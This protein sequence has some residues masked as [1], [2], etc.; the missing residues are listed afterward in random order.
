M[1]ST[2]ANISVP[3]GCNVDRQIH[4][5]P[6]LPRTEKS[7][8]GGVVVSKAPETTRRQTGAPAV[9]DF[10]GRTPRDCS[11]Q[12]PQTG[13]RRQALT[14]D[15]RV[16]V[17][18]ARFT[19]TS[20]P[21]VVPSL[22][23]PNWSRKTALLPWRIGSSLLL[24]NEFC[25][26]MVW[27]PPSK[28]ETDTQA[29][30]FCVG[31]RGASHGRIVAAT[32]KRKSRRILGRNHSGAVPAVLGSKANAEAHLPKGNAFANLESLATYHRRTRNLSYRAR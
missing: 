9:T 27:M 19:F 1:G 29:P 4:P 23:L 16:G 32:L 12:P 22:P 15:L 28:R 20:P 18:G 31:M 10:L 11:G 5:F 8:F 14:F 13:D 7:P 25:T 3:L 17:V 21:G 2:S 6:A 26:P 24:S 30:S